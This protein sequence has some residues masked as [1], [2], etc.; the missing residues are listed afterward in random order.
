MDFTDQIN[1]TISLSSSPKRIVSV[2]PSQTELLF[3]LGLE[4]EVVG[5]TKFCVHPSDWFRSK[6]RVGGTK[7]LN[8][9]KIEALQPDLI[10]ANKEENTEA[11]IKH[12]Q[13][14]F[15]VWTSDISTLN[16]SLIM[17]KSVGQLTNTEEKAQLLI[18]K[19]QQEFNA[20]RNH[21]KQTTTALYFIWQEPF[22]SVGKD[23]II[24]HLMEYAGLKNV[25]SYANR[26][27]KVSE[28]DI[29]QL[30]PDIILLSSEPY[31]FKEKHIATFQKLCPKSKVI[32]VDGELF[33]WYGSRLQYAPK[34]F[35]EL[36]V[37]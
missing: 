31:P 27:P 7:N 13:Q 6:T 18:N 33:S 35:F 29:I 28:E 5:I 4:D 22:M 2:V 20:Y 9:Q 25:M 37:E 1:H 23:T 30:Q 10:I 34:Y 16:D 24:H 17:I 12:L 32:L 21:F 26:Y 3:E 19:I 11:E 8:I 36:F 15:P 14:K